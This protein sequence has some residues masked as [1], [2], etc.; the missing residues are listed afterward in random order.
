MGLISGSFLVGLAVSGFAFAAVAAPSVHADGSASI[1]TVQGSSS[2]RFGPRWANFVGVGSG[3]G[4]TSPF[5]QTDAVGGS[6]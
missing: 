1:T 6:S 4:G 2:E 5:A 3:F